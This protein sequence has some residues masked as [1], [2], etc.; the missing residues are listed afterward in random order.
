MTEYTIHISGNSN[1]SNLVLN[2]TSAS[3]SDYNPPNPPKPQINEDIIGSILDPST[4]YWVTGG[5]GGS[6][7]C[8]DNYASEAAIKC[9][10][11]GGN[12]FDAAVACMT[13]LGLT[14]PG[15]CGI[16]GGGYAVLYKADTKRVETMDFREVAPLKTNPYFDL[17][18]SG[19]IT[20]QQGTS[21]G[22][23]GTPMFF[24]ELLERH[25]TYT[26]EQCFK[27]AIKLANNGFLIDDNLNI[28]IKAQKYVIKNFPETSAKYL[29][30]SFNELPTGTTIKNPDYA[31]TLQLIADTNCDAFYS[32]IIADDIVKCVVN[33]PCVASPTL[34]SSTGV[35]T[36]LTISGGVMQKEDL[37]LYHIRINPPIKT[38]FRDVDVYVVP[39][40]TSGGLLIA[41]G[42]ALYQ[43][44]YPTVTRDASGVADS[45]YNRL[46][47]MKYAFAD[48][49]VY[50]ADPMFYPVPVRAILDPSYIADRVATIKVDNS[51]NKVVI[52]GKPSPIYSS[53]DFSGNNNILALQYQAITDPTTIG[54][55]TGLIVTD[56]FGNIACITFTIEQIFG[57][58]MTVP[59]R[60]FVLNNELTDFNNTTRNGII[61]ANSPE[62]YKRP[63]SSMTPILVFKNGLPLIALSAS[64]GLRIPGAIFEAIVNKV[65]Y[66]Y[67]IENILLEGRYYQFNGS[68]T[69]YDNQANDQ[70]GNQYSAMK[71]LT[72]Y[73]GVP[74]SHFSYNSGSTAMACITFD[75]VKKSGFNLPVT[76]NSKSLGSAKTINANP[77]YNK[78]TDTWVPPVV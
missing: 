76:T 49:N 12:A 74:Q 2:S 67:S 52:A 11:S 5:T 39:P 20:R 16:G 56:R 48:R 65:D 78:N 35:V 69:G 43:G 29:D 47:A 32:G 50:V 17:N 64:G 6:V 14:K 38:R 40:S 73:K 57:C 75:G 26:L 58:G 31:N 45:Y 63:R 51:L 53:F 13:V 46:L 41:E 62:P 3:I 34:T 25:G 9:L 8:A 44:L 19:T 28:S 68:T 21:V 4:T 66:G 37:E 54:S 22:V 55:T 10:E 7:A 33:P 36:P 24:K 72:T 18:S 77:I 23:P 70:S 60:G 1:A 42:L 27:P 59:G 15:N 30:A 61:T 71:L